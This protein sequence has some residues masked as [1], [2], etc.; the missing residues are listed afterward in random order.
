MRPAIVS[1]ALALGACGP[2]PRAPTVS[3]VQAKQPRM[4]DAVRAA[5]AVFIQAAQAGDVRA[6]SRLFAD[7]AVLITHRSDTIRGRSVIA[8]S[9][10]TVRPGALNARFWF[11]RFPPLRGCIDGAYEHGEFTA[12]V[13]YT[14]GATDTVH[15]QVVVRW[16]RDSLGN[17][18]IQ[19]AAFAEHEIARPLRRGECVDRATLQQQASRLSVTL[20]PFL[21]P[22]GGPSGSVERVLRAQGWHDPGYV[23]PSGRRCY[24][25]ETPQS[26]GPAAVRVTSGLGQVRYRLSRSI[27][28]VLFLSTSPQGSTIAHNVADSSELELSWSGGLGGALLSYQRSGF[29]AEAGPA[30]EVAHWRIEDRALPY[31]ASVVYET[32]FRSSTL[33]VVTGGGITSAV[34]G[35]WFLDLHAEVRRFLHTR[36]RGTPRFQQSQVTNNSYFIG[37]GIGLAF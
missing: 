13:R 9:L 32:S 24:Y 12:E 25:G 23:C 10:T 21:R 33:G 7:D 1:V 17:A 37:L 27:A 34:L 5:Q 11:A 6:M 29:H 19:R 4:E 20:Y 15:A 36:L 26:Y 28:A 22:F 2:L 18:Q 35:L 3:P 30:L 31:N 14:K 8:D 16:G